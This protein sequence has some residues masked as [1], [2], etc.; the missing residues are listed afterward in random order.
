MHGTNILVAKCSGFV[1]QKPVGKRCKS[2][3]VMEEPTDQPRIDGKSRLE[4]VRCTLI[5]TSELN[6]G[7]FS[8]GI[9]DMPTLKY[10][11][12]R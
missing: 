8:L 6:H 7:N 3:L 1:L 10:Y 5:N 12:F 9:P 4:L 11:R 2:D